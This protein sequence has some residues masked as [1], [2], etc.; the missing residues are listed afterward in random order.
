VKVSSYLADV[1]GTLLGK[2]LD[3]SSQEVLKIDI[4]NPSSQAVTT[5]CAPVL[6]KV[7]EIVSNNISDPIP[8]VHD[9]SPGSEF[10][11]KLFEVAVNHKQGNK[12]KLADSIDR[13]VASASMTRQ[14]DVVTRLGMLLK[15]EFLLEEGRVQGALS[16]F[17]E[18]I[19]GE[20][21]NVRA[22]LGVARCFEKMG[23]FNK[24]LEIW[25]II[26]SILQKQSGREEGG[27]PLDFVGRIIQVLFPFMQ[28]SLEESLVTWARKCFKMEE[29]YDAA[30]KFLD[31]IALFSNQEGALESIDIG[32]VKQEAALALLIV[33]NVPVSLAL[34]Q[35]LI[36]GRRKAGKRKQREGTQNEVVLKFL[37]AKCHFLNN[38]F[39]TALLYLDQSLR[40]CL[41][42]MAEHSRGKVIKCD[43][44]GE[45][46]NSESDMLSVLVRV[47]AR[48]YFEKA[49]V[50]KGLKDHKSFKLSL[51]SALKLDP[52]H[53]FGKYYLD[54]LEADITKHKAEVEALKNSMV[55][56]PVKSLR[57]GDKSFDVGLRFL[58]DCYSIHVIQDVEV[59]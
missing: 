12:L 29:Y 43:V 25:N 30:E 39:D 15:G 9:T 40:S 8:I 52:N 51:K 27:C 21:A 41:A 28:I 34:C 1:K 56:F 44:V 54:F 13:L 17:G 45:E 50:Y 48:L 16:S 47:R 55:K 3:A 22:Y 23:K 42:E 24:E 53:E 6:R 49:L 36:L 11:S 31:A 38:E 5:S 59:D 10:L 37:I 19:K 58:L 35:D 2:D 7:I 46:V 33:G 57:C 32:E 20:G 18:V 4:V 14:P 26:S